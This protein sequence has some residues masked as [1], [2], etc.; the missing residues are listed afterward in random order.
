M[1]LCVKNSYDEKKY[2]NY[3]TGHVI[4]FEIYIN[5]NAN[6]KSNKTIDGVKR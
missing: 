1:F 5:Q 3:V 6:K 4:L 2:K